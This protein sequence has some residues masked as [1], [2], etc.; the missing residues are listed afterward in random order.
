MKNAAAH[1]R[2]HYVD[3]LI[4]LCLLASRLDP[5]FFFWRTVYRSKAP[6]RP[7]KVEVQQRGCLPVCAFRVI[8]RDGLGAKILTSRGDCYLGMAQA[9]WRTNQVAIFVDGMYCGQ[10]QTAYD[11]AAGKPLQDHALDD[12]LRSAIQTS[13]SLTVKDLEPFNGDALAWAAAGRGSTAFHDR[14]HRLWHS[15]L[16]P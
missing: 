8:L 2:N 1:P 9:V 13:Y 14:H 12:A 3:W 15:L 5:S 11:L 6:N 4:V 7:V 16:L 10:F